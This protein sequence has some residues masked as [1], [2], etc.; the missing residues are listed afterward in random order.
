MIEPFLGRMLVEVIREDGDEYLK[1]KIAAEKDGKVSKE[2]LE[3]FQFVFG[4]DSVDPQT[5][6][7][8]F[9]RSTAKP[10]ITKGRIVKMAPDCFGEAFQSRFGKDR[11]YP[12]VGDIVIF[13]PNKSYQVDAENK[14]H[15]VD[16]CELV[17]FIKEDKKV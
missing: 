13:T 1:Q 3:K 15:I 14:F 16:D 7:K 10:G 9:K 6:E 8:K 5:G 4:E 2:F 12:S 11:D 17:G